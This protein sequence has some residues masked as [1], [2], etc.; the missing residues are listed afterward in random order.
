MATYRR[1]LYTTPTPTSCW[2]GVIDVITP[3]STVKASLA[4]GF[5][6]SGVGGSCGSAM[7]SAVVSVVDA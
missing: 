4:V 5:I 6:G 1:L 3:I 2:M 7:G